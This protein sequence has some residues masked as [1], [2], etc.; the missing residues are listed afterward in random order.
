MAVS[1]ETADEAY[2]ARM[3][4]WRMR[5]EQV[6]A[7]PPIDRYM[8]DLQARPAPWL[9]LYRLERRPPT[10]TRHPHPA[11]NTQHPSTA[12]LRT[13]LAGGFTRG[14]PLTPQPLAQHQGFFVIK[15]AVRPEEL[16]ALN[17]QVDAANPDA[18]KEMGITAGEAREMMAD[19]HE[20]RVAI[21]HPWTRV[22]G[23]HIDLLRR[24][25]VLK[26]GQPPEPVTAVSL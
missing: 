24:K 2:A 11:P 25:I 1:Y 16:A 3:E 13:Y 4:L 22:R 12:S 17:A 6:T 7:V 10:A 18:G 21:L 19:P 14:Q 5:Q 15:G 9:R 26:L 20:P 8:F 23:V